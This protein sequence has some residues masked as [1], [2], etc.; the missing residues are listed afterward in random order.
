MNRKIATIVPI[1]H[2]DYIRDDS[3][4]MALSYLVDYTKY[5]QFM[6]DRAT[7]GQYVILDNST[8]ELSEPEN[9]SRYLEKAN[10]IRASCIVLPD[11][12]KDS[13]RT[14]EAVE[15]ALTYI[16]RTKVVHKFDIMVIPQGRTVNEWILS[17]AQMAS[18]LRQYPYR[19]LWRRYVI[20]ISYRYGFMFDSD[21]GVAVQ[22]LEKYVC[23]DDLYNCKIHLLGCDTDPRKEVKPLLSRFTVQGVDSSYA[24]VYAK[25]KIQMTPEIL[26][27]PRPPR[28]VNFVE[29]VYNENLLLNNIEVWRQACRP[30]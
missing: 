6:R 17:A 9:F 24:S 10:D 7:D 12:F 16:S 3:Y 27:W 20:G 14:F 28:E 5:A 1:E 23:G 18:L 8:I 21:R 15:Q 2:L 19:M 22:Y 13:E 30:D 4:I 29:D 25:H 26:A 11:Y